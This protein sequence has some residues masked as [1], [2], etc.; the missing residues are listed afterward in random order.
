MIVSDVDIVESEGLGTLKIA[1]HSL[2][3]LHKICSPTSFH[4]VSCIS[5]YARRY[6]PCMVLKYV[7]TARPSLLRISKYQFPR[8]AEKIPV[9]LRGPNYEC[10]GTTKEFHVC[11][12]PP[13]HANRNV[14]TV[15][16]SMSW[17]LAQDG[18]GVSSREGTLSVR[19]S[20]S[21]SAERLKGREAYSRCS[22]RGLRS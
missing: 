22:R 10:M 6:G 8:L 13:G 20:S 3:F 12:T 11:L 16:A 2:L 15:F 5:H 19:I 17:A 21:G 18:K 9:S 14:E 1:K 7:A 4:P